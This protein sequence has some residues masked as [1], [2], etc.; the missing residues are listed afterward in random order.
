MTTFKDRHPLCPKVRFFD[1]F[2][3][4][5]A[6]KVAMQMLDFWQSIRNAKKGHR[7]G[8]VVS[9]TIDV[10][11]AILGCLAVTMED[12][13]E[14]QEQ[15][16]VE[17]ILTGNY[18]AFINRDTLTA[19]INNGKEFKNSRLDPRTVSNQINRLLEIGFLIEKRNYRVCYDEGTGQLCNPTPDLL[20]SRGNGRIQLFINPKVFQ[21][22]KKF[23]AEFEALKA[24]LRNTFLIDSTLPFSYDNLV[25][26][27]IDSQVDCGQKALDDLKVALATA[28]CSNIQ[29]NKEQ[30][31]QL[32]E[33]S[34]NSAR[35]K[36][37]KRPKFREVNQYQRHEL[38]NLVLSSF[39]PERA[40]TSTV[41]SN[42]RAALDGKL[43]LVAFDIEAYR[44]KQ[45]NS[46]T[47]RDKYQ[48]ANENKKAWM[49]RNFTKKLPC[50]ETS[51][52]EILTN[53]LSIQ[54]A[55]AKNKG[56]YHK[57]QRPNNDPGQ[58]LESSNF[59]YAIDFALNNW[60][61]QSN[62]VLSKNR[63][64]NSY[65]D[66]NKALY[67]FY[68]RIVRVNNEKGLLQGYVY[69]VQQLK[70]IEKELL[71]AYISEASKKSLLVAL[72]NRIAPLFKIFSPQ[73]KRYLY[74]CAMNQP[75]NA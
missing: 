62:K 22:D 10:M 37:E 8:G 15:V 56:Y 4:K 60:R 39:F 35:K 2:N 69:A 23:A 52:L 66:Q 68:R 73:E 59:Q 36:E 24:Y 47:A 63:E 30:V 45:V 50:V 1:V 7:R 33:N 42:A 18:F 41:L 17:A 11:H 25:K 55:H 31:R 58:F 29:K 46:Y 34:K 44:A 61:R 32:E 26:K 13:R 28:N 12:M 65:L 64:Y 72:K 51:S 40:F 19:R 5:A 57:I 21:V 67:Q 6:A 14:N 9:S 75:K 71:Q 70:K 48:K 43:D 27:E 54:E 3:K 53:A 38:F 20:Y 74:Q 49:L 16:F